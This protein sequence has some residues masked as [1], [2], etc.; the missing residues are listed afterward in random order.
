MTKLEN[1]NAVKHGAFAVFLIM[2]DEDP[3]EF[4][5]LLADLVEEWNPEGRCENEKI[6][7]IA[8]SMWRKR[9]FRKH[10]GKSNGKTRQKR[11]IHRPHPRS[12]H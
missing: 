4:E 9:R 5:A 10:M 7:S 11:G 8:M 2:P 6:E 1:K 3:N 12:R